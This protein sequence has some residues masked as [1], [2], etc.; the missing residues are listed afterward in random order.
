MTEYCEHGNET[1][2]SI[3]KRDNDQ[4]LERIL[5]SRRGFVPCS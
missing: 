4:L 2:G 3:K 1:T 5:A